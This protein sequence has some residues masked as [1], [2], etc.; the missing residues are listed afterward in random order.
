MWPAKYVYMEKKSFNDCKI[1]QL[2]RA[3]ND[4]SCAFGIVISIMFRS[5]KLAYFF[6][7]KEK[8]T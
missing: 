8:D 4:S 5:A 6:I 1:F 2:I 7:L 3:I